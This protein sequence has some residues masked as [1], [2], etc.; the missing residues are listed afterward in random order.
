MLQLEN[1]LFLRV[2][3]GTDNWKTFYLSP[4]NIVKLEVKMFF[5]VFFFFLLLLVSEN[6]FRKFIW[7]REENMRSGK[8]I[9]RYVPCIVSWFQGKGFEWIRIMLMETTVC[10]SCN[11]ID[12]KAFHNF[13]D[14]WGMIIRSQQSNKFRN[15]PPNET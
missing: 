12:K 13:T 3:Y 5:F 15:Y 6:V 11:A 1:P 9:L 10:L 7:E 8:I 4:N 2:W 14:V